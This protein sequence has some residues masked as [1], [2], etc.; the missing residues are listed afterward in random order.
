VDLETLASNSLDRLIPQAETLG[1][2]LCSEFHETHLRALV[3]P[4]RVEQILLILV[5]N[6]MKHSPNGGSVWVDGAAV[7]I[8]AIEKQPRAGSVDRVPFELPVGEWAVISVT[9]AGAGIPDE[10]LPHVFDRFYRA[11]ESR[12]RNRGGSGLGLSIAKALV[13]AHF[14]HIWLESP[15]T[16]PRVAAGIP[17]TTASFALPLS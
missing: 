8:E 1:V 17:G 5:D 13:E 15:S 12:S 2:E 9:D 11:D 10:N 14:G 4:D 16:S 3:D 6:A 7:T